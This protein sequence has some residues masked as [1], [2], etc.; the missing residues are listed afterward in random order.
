MSGYDEFA[1]FRENA[2]E[3]GIPWRGEPSVA[4]RAV[5]VDGEREVSA[6]VWGDRDPELVL[7]HGGAQN[8]HTWD[9]LALCLDRPLVAVDLPGH[10]HS[11]WRRE[12]D[13]GPPALAEDVARAVRV[14]APDARAVVGMSLGGLTATCLAE[15]HPGLVSRLVVVDVTPG[16]DH[17]KAA[18]IVD[19]VSGPESFPSF[20]A[21]LERTLRFNPTRSEASL[22]R[23]VLHNAARR[24]DGSWSWRYDPTR[25]WRSEGGGVP[26]FSSLWSAVEA[27]RAP[28]ML[29]RGGASGV[30]GDE[31][32]AELRK[33]QPDVRIETVAGAGHSIQGDRP[34]ELAALIDDFIR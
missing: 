13:Y 9:T 16:T 3:F 17:A 26:D 15:R 7:L 11:G 22:R 25:R 20:D 4:R 19:F 2:E 10:G 18:P 21:I 1:H 5:A 24:A 32:L 28:M 14:L 29:V 23:G 12:H 31:D 6:L 34:L 8:A 27:V 30:V 33:R